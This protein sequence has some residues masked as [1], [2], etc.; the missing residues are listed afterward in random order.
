MDIEIGEL[1][2]RCKN[3]QSQPIA[4]EPASSSNPTIRRHRT[5]LTLYDARG[6]EAGSL[7]VELRDPAAPVD[8]PVIDSAGDDHERS[9]PTSPPIADPVQELAEDSDGGILD[10]LRRA[11]G[12][13]KMAADL[14]NETAEVHPGFTAQ[15]ISIGFTPDY[16]NSLAPTQILLGSSWNQRS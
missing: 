7:V 16:L 10:Y 14:L 3:N 5:T 1:L 15:A 8:E 12:K 2:D 11:A 9:L 13:T 4:P 6:Q